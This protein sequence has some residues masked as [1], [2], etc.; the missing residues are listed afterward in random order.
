MAAHAHYANVDEFR[1][2][3]TSAFASGQGVAIN[4]HR[5]ELGMIGGGHFSPAVA[6]N[7]NADRFLVLDVSRYK[8]PAFWA[9][10]NDLFAAMNTTD[11]AS[12]TSR[13]WAVV[14]QA[15]H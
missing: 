4:F 6:Y 13:G 3:A 12:L 7:K 14:G 10:A 11:S 9:T 2:A 15:M 8:Y 1:T 5:S